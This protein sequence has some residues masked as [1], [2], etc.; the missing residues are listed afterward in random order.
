[1]LNVFSYGNEPRIFQI[2]KSIASL[3][4]RQTPVTAYY[5][6]FKALWEEL[7]NFKVHHVCTCEAVKHLTDEHNQEC[8]MQFLMGL[9]E[10]YSHVRVQI[11]LM[12][13]LPS[14]NKVFSLIVQE[15]R[16]R[17]LPL[18]PHTLPRIVLSLPVVRALKILKILSINSQTSHMLRRKIVPPVATVVLLATLWTNVTSY[19]AILLDTN[20]DLRHLH[21]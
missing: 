20:L 14:I 5:T 21:Q 8:I 11:Q 19:M 2:Q 9:N 16:Q 3:S 6:K 10:S 4:Q 13:P 1:M 15:E 18:L 17:V 7:S 12:E